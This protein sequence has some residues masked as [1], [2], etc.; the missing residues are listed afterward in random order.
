MARKRLHLIG[1]LP[2][3]ADPDSRLPPQPPS[4][5]GSVEKSVGVP[6]FPPSSFGLFEIKYRLM[7]HARESVRRDTDRGI[8]QVN[9]SGVLGFV[10]AALGLVIAVLVTSSPSRAQQPDD[11]FTPADRWAHYVHRTYSPIRM[12]IL[13]ADTAIDHGLRDPHCWDESASSYGMRYARA[14]QRR[15]VR[16]DSANVPVDAPANAC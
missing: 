12:S 2:S 4:G 13:A 8:G 11:P 6:L 3:G 9:P 7:A 15:V 16:N 10:R 1:R 5:S 14:F